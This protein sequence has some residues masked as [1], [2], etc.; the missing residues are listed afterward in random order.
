MNYVDDFS[1]KVVDSVSNE[2]RADVREME[3]NFSNALHEFKNKILGLPDQNKE[4]RALT[5]SLPS[6]R[7]LFFSNGIGAD[8]TEMELLFYQA[9]DEFKIKMLG[10]VNENIKKRLFIPELPL[11]RHSENKDFMP[12]S[13]CSTSDFLHPRFREICGALHSP[14]VF[15]RKLWEWVFIVHKL[16]ANGV[17]RKGNKGLVFGVGNESL[18]AYFASLGVAVLATDAP[19]EIVEVWRKNNQHSDSLDALKRPGIVSG[20][21]FDELVSFRYADMKNIPP[22]LKGFDFVWSSCC[23]EHL[24]SLEA[25]IQF[26]IDSVEKTLKPGGVAVH[27]TEFNLSSNEDTLTDGDTVIYRMSDI[28]NCIDRLKDSGHCVEAFSLAPDVHITDYF[29]DMPP[30]SSDPHL[31]HRLDKYVATSVGLVIKK[32]EDLR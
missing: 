12:H 14:H 3:L 13:T 4:K 2:I 19:P 1:E 21:E 27:T 25:G 15:S 22:D 8:V 9:L 31:R 18:P 28:L 23:F 17:L 30:Y 11:L 6:L 32:A 7:S 26:V 16:M 5:P 10:L 29:V 24:G 20:H